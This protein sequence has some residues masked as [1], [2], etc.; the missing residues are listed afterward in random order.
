M[1]ELIILTGIIRLL[2]L[3]FLVIPELTEAKLCPLFCLLGYN[4]VTAL[5]SD[6]ETASKIQIWIKIV[7]A[8]FLCIIIFIF[9]HNNV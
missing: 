5:P 2:F 4:K 8:H 9:I 7:F 1:T 6:W 3:T